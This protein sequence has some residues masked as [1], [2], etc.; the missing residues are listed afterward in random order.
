MVYRGHIWLVWDKGHYERYAFLGFWS[1]SLY[2]GFHK[3]SRKVGM[4]FH[5]DVPTAKYLYFLTLSR[6][7]Q[8][9]K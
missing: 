9:R 4:P 2:L 7:Y 6:E 3:V 5:S 8:D 1:S